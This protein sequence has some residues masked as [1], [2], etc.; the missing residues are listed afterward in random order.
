MLRRALVG[1]FA[2]GRA[3]EDMAEEAAAAA[4]VGKAIAALGERVEARVEPR[5]AEQRVEAVP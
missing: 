5:E 3:T 1:L 4:E 2:G